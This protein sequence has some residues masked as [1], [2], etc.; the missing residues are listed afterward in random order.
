MTFNLPS[1][2]LPENGKR[3]LRVDGCEVVFSTKLLFRGYWTAMVPTS[4]DRLT[5]VAL[6]DPYNNGIITFSSPE[7]AIT[8]V[9]KYLATLPPSDQSTDH[10]DLSAVDAHKRRLA[11]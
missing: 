1:N 5:W 2:W 4:S 8:A 7:T 11:S 10:D 6:S 9:E 3:F